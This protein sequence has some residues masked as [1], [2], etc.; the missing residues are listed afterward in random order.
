[1][2]LCANQHT[3]AAFD[4]EYRHSANMGAQMT[5]ERFSDHY[6]DRFGY[7]IQGLVGVSS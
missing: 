6:L 2:F 3:P 4:L 7:L 5:R 1:V